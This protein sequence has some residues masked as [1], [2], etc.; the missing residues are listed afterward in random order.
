MFKPKFK[1]V[2]NILALI[3]LANAYISIDEQCQMVNNVIKKTDSIES[4][5]FF[6][7]VVCDVN[8]KNVIQLNLSDLDLTSVSTDI[9]KLPLVALDLSDNK[10][11]KSLPKEIGNLAHL[12]I[13]NLSDLP[14]LTSLPDTITLLKELN[15]LMINNDIS[16]KQLPVNIGN[17]SKL[18]QLYAIGTGLESLPP[19]IVNLKS[20]IIAN[21]AQSKNLTGK[22][23]ELSKDVICN[24]SETQICHYADVE[25]SYKW[26]L[27]ATI[28]CDKINISPIT[29]GMINT[30]INL[31]DEDEE[32]DG[33][34]G[35]GYGVCPN[36]ECC[37][38]YGYCGT[39]DEH[40]NVASE[41]QTNYGRCFETDASGNR[42]TVGVIVE[43]VTKTTTQAPTPTPSTSKSY[44]CGK[45]Y[46]SCG[47]GLC[48]SRFGWC[49]LTEEFCDPK[50]CQSQYGV[51]WDK[52]AST[53]VTTPVYKSVPGR[54]G[55]VYGPCPTGFCCSRYGWCGTSESFCA[56]NKCQPNYGLCSNTA[57]IT[58]DTIVRDDGRCGQGF[59]RCSA[60]TCCSKYGWCGTSDIY[61]YIRSGCQ[62]NYGFCK[63]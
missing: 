56:A 60:G 13:L 20:L 58:D 8:M 19:T 12:E 54:C 5:C 40:C 11:L 45:G 16:L 53:T 48:C 23:P 28:H 22:V 43:S 50:T 1:N 36:S 34:C 26:S 44:R 49:G 3:S 55:S 27:P 7:R 29:M 14:E 39:T 52:S 57:T 46:G 30:N 24:Y 32:P 38:K 9:T 33:R 15:I 6:E 42:V 63:D 51:C 18:N 59:G 10:N 37:S 62:P 4:C 35:K 61:C 47:R 17:L 21:F 41:F 2:I 31:D 25:Y